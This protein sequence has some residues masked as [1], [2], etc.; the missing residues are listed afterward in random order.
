ML[1]SKRRT[2]EDWV[3]FVKRSTHESEDLAEKYGASDWNT[4]QIL[5]KWRFAGKTGRHTD[6]RWSTRLLAWKPWFQHLPLRRV[7]RPDTRWE[8]LFV[9]E[10][11]SEWEKYTRDEDLWAIKAKQSELAIHIDSCFVYMILLR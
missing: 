10:M 1:S 3:E 9:K 2:D 8:D 7:G 6:F 5:A 11:G 4:L